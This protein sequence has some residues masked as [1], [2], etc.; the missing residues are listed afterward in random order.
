MFGFR[1]RQRRGM[2]IG[3]KKGDFI[4]L[5]YW[6]NCVL[7]VKDIGSHSLWGRL[8]DIREGQFVEENFVSE[9]NQ[10]WIKSLT[11]KDVLKK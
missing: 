9:L 5:P 1:T 10:P 7:Q 3:I 11:V 4:R 8:E 6:T 2:D